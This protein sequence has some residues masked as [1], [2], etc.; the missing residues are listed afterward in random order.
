M[1]LQV[2]A[3]DHHLLRAL[4][5]QAGKADG[6]GLV[7]L[8]RFDEIFGRNFD[9]EIHHRVAVVR[10]DNLDEIFSDVV[11]VAFHGG[12]HDFAAGRGIGFFHELLEV[13]DGGLHRFRRLKHFGDDQLVVVEETA[14]LAHA[15]HQRSVD[16]V[17][18]GDAFSALAVEIG[19]QTVLG[20]L[21]NVIREALV[22]REIGSLLLVFF[23]G[24][25]EVCGDGGDMKL[26]DRD[27]LFTGSVRAN[28]RA[29]F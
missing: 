25:A 21:D 22:E 14:D 7:L 10:E 2:A 28:L 16:D 12:Q 6:V 23:Y 11:N 19:N 13:S 18:R 29:R 4:D 20:A 3:G 26:I 9:A 24:V 5:E 17:E 1:S 27:F 15:S 8:V